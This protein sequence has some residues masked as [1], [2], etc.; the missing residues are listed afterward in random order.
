M[1]KTSQTLSEILQSY[2]LNRYAAQKGKLHDKYQRVLQILHREFG[3]QLADNPFQS[4]SLA[5]G[6][7]INVKF[8]LDMVVP[9]KR[10]A[11][12]SPEAMYKAI[13]K[14]L[15]RNEYKPRYQKVSFGVPV[16]KSF[17]DVVPGLEINP[18]NY[19]ASGGDLLLWD[20][21]NSEVIKT[22]INRQLAHLK[23]AG[24][25][26]LKLIR[27]MK[28]WKHHHSVNFKSFMLELLVINAYKNRKC[29]TFEA[30]LVWTFQHISQH[31][32]LSLT[33]PGNRSN[34]V[35]RDLKSVT[36]SDTANRMGKVAKK[37][38]VAFRD[39]DLAVVRGLFP[40]R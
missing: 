9:F 37:L 10:G 30:Q 7:P 29:A 36:L 16:G 2:S 40:R 34:N 14:L 5:K 31:L 28:I 24:T 18:N 25:D 3:D 39:G 19:L 12:D 1:I 20:S 4:G 15:Q 23:S 38:E 13:G 21:R 22:N 26:V 33:D 35:L 32:H 6:T 27:F 11:F 17:L 8:D